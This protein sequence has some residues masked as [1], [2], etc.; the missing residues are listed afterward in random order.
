LTQSPNTLPA[1]TT[2]DLEIGADSGGSTRNSNA[3][4][5]RAAFF[6]S[7]PTQAVV[8]SLYNQGITP[9]PV[10][11]PFFPQVQDDIVNYEVVGY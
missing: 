5:N 9:P 6:Q 8:T 1:G 7:G 10:M 4:I 11:F 2:F 3:I